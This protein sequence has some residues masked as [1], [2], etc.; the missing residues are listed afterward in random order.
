MGNA[1]SGTGRKKGARE[2]GAAAG[3]SPLFERVSPIAIPI[4]AE[5]ELAL[6]ARHAATHGIARCEFCDKPIDTASD[7]NGSGLYVW[8][9]GDESR[10][11]EPPLCATCA[12]S[13]GINASRLFMIEDDG[14]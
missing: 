1:W 13:A 8:A 4:D 9:R 14:E 5:A 7:Q 2:A 10:Y 3:A 6:K 12:L 11:E